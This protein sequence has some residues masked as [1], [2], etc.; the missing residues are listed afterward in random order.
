[1]LAS[2]FA[3]TSVAAD[4]KSYAGGKIIGATQNRIGS[5]AIRPDYA[6]AKPMPLPQAS[7][8]AEVIFGKAA[9][10]G[11]PSTV[12]GT[13]GTGKETMGTIPGLKLKGSSTQSNSGIESQDYGTGNQVYTTARVDP[14]SNW[15]SKFYPFRI[16]GKLYFQIGSDWYV[17]SASLIKKGL[18]VTAAHCVSDYGAS[19]FYSNWEFIPAL[20][21]SFTPF[22]T[23][24]SSAAYVLNSYYNGTDG[25][26]Q[27]GVICPNDVAVIVIAPQS[28]AYPGT[29]TGTYGVGTN[30]AGFNGSSQ[31]L[32]TQLGYPQSLDSG[33]IMERTDS[34]GYKY[35]TY[36]N[37]TIIGSAMT[38]GSSGGPWLVNLGVSPSGIVTGSY[39][40]RNV[41]VG[42]TSWGYTST[43]VQQQGASSFT[44]TNITSLISTACTA[45]PAAC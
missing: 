25:C 27:Y 29:T 30:G 40:T 28:A 26:Y 37:N 21:S 36:S 5:K 20:K 18:L 34:Q 35:S 31:A 22:G 16:T 7:A 15:T 33:I 12:A 13:E 39:G 14:S 24:Y 6:N 8:P 38:G 17:C 10:T 43:A 23:W 32:I 11:T 4:I 1:M 3:T 44:S 45:Y 42:V 19:T 2:T 9:S 41:V